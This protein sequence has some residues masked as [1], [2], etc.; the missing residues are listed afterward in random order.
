M[1][2][3][4]RSASGETSPFGTV[5][6]ALCIVIYLVALVQGAVRVYL[7]I[8]QRKITAS[9][10]FNSIANL[11]LSAGTRSF[12]DERFIETINNALV[13]SKSIEALII[14]GPEGEYAFEKEKGKAVLWINN[15][16]RF[17][18]RFSFYSQGLYLPL[19]INNL[20]NTNIS[21]VASA[22]DFAQ[23]IMILK[24]TLFLI[25]IGFALAF[26]T[27]LLQTLLGKTP[28]KLSEKMDAAPAYISREPEIRETSAQAE[29]LKAEEIKT[30]DVEESVPK[31]LY[32]PRSNIGWE[33]YTKDR[34]DSELHRCASTEKDLTL[35]AMEFT[36]NLNDSQFKQAAE[37]AVSFFTSRDL[38]FERGKHGIT[39]IYP[40]IDLENGFSKSQKFHERIKEKIFLSKGTENSFCIGL[41]SRAGRLLNAGRMMMEA[42]EALKK[43]ETDSPPIVAFKINLDKYREFIRKK[44]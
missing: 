27:M 34:L 36:V 21:A 44:G 41:T 13:S 42:D 2:T 38:L 19:P 6:A 22:F 39:V 10:E 23:F 43:A 40:G 24:E 37:E 30:D 9:N 7:S 16:P 14:T 4:Q 28:E 25:L 18:N 35:L 20:R 31:G 11:A 12:M 33:E 5:I 15:S 17:I 1:K 26:V 3:Q 32:S 29:K 8:D